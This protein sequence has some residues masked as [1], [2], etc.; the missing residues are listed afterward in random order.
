VASPTFEEEFLSHR[1]NLLQ[2]QK[3]AQDAG[4]AEE[5]ELV[6]SALKLYDNYIT[7]VDYAAMIRGDFTSSIAALNDYVDA[8]K[9]I[10]KANSKFFSWRSNFAGSIIPEFMYRTADVTLRKLDLKPY[11]S[12]GDSVLEISPDPKGRGFRI[13]RKDQDFCVGFSKLSVIEDGQEITIVV[14]CVT[15]EIKTNIDI[16]K[17]NGLEY[18]AKRLKNSF[19]AAKYLLVTETLDFSLLDNRASG[20]IDEVYV[21]R[22]QVRSK[23]RV[24]GGKAPLQPDVFQH[25][26]RDIVGACIRSTQS[27]GHVY[28]RLDKGRLI[29]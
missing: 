26:V 14:P 2:K 16:N 22:K 4:I 18:T 27:A 25:L 17:I 11:Y 6:A 9:K 13:I 20:P 24:E 15:A 8:A 7:K 12:K 5:K 29:P 10:E 1:N 21:L 23:A 28:D 19:P 3:I